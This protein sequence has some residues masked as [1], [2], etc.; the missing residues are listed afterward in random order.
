MYTL[1]RKKLGGLRREVIEFARELVRTPS[2][3]LEEGLVAEKVRRELELSGYDKVVSDDFGNVV[4]IKLGRETKPNLLLISHM[5][6]VGPASAERWE[7]DP[8]GAEIRDGRLYGLGASDCKGGLA[9][10]VYAGALLSASLL[11][12]RG[13]LVFAATVAEGNG[14]SVG[15]RGLLE[16]TLPDLGITPD[17]AVLGE[18]TD[19]GLYY[20]HDGWVELKLVVEGPNPFHVEDAARTIAEN[21]A[22]DGPAGEGEPAS[23]A[24]R[25]ED[26]PGARRATLLMSRRLKASIPVGEVVDQVRREA[27]RAAAGDT[28]VEVGVQEKREC[29]YNGRYEIVRNLANAWAIDPYDVLVERAR[30][31]LAAGGAEVRPRR[32]RLGR[33]GMGT[34][35]GT[36]VNDYKISTVGYGP[37]NEEVAHSYNEY[38]EV[39]KMVEAVYG[40]AVIAHSL[41]GIPVFGWTSDEI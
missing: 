32:W 28:A 37:G 12:L 19:L 38:V 4:G 5:D 34:A 8:Y 35:G 27:V 26:L 3:T 1:L 36:L 13:N 40:T 2:L 11:P 23:S 6:T 18:P 14:R 33:L 24:P 7:S 21:L 9:A 15:V 16:K 30:Q 25:F 22:V 31:A 41:V 10:Q 20:G 17:Y 29:L 39:E